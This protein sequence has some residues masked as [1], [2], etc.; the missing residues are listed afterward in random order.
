[1]ITAPDIDEAVEKP[2]ETEES[3]SRDLPAPSES[4]LEKGFATDPSV[5]PLLWPS[6]KKWRLAIT[7]SITGL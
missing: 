3:K 1:M 5:N 2:E 4:A 6:S 7:I